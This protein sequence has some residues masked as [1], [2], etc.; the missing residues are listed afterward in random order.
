MMGLLV[1]VCYAEVMLNF[2]V[3]L[4]G[5]GDENIPGNLN[6]PKDLT[7]SI[8]VAIDAYTLYL[9]EGCDNTTLRLI[10][11]DETVAFSTFITTGATSVT[12]PETL[13]G[14]YRLEIERGAFTFYFE[15][16]L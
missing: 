8:S 7:D 3:S 2:N 4:N 13:S 10:S 12:L 6:H 14:E 5:A 15:I 1:P 9:Y 16:E 11:S